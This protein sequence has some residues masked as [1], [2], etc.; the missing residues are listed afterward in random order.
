LR[1]A[2]IEGNA[3]GALAAM[4]FGAQPSLPTALALQQFCAER[5]ADAG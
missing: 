5:F 1:R 3:A 2:V 4:T